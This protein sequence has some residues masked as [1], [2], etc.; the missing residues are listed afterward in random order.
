MALTAYNC[1]HCV[2]STPELLGFPN[3]GNGN[4][5]LVDLRISRGDLDPFSAPKNQNFDTV[6]MLCASPDHDGAVSIPVGA[7]RPNVF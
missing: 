4:S 2:M 5:Q 6:R 1:I 3:G 7:D